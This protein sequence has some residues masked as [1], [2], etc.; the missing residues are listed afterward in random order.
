VIDSLRRLFFTCLAPLLL[1]ACISL[2]ATF[3]KVLS[4]LPPGWFYGAAAGVGI[5]VLYR[6]ALGLPQGFYVLGHELTHMLAAKATGKKILNADI[7]GNWRSGYVVTSGANMWIRLA[8]YAISF[9]NVFL[10]IVWLVASRFYP[11]PSFSY[12]LLAFA[13][14]AMNAEFT[15]RGFLQEQPDLAFSG[16]V[17]S[18]AYALLWAMLFLPVFFWP[19]SEIGWREMVRFYGEWFG[20]SYRWFLWITSSFA[21]V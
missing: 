4:I 16:R 3:G 21:W 11:L 20:K 18:A 12:L 9:H 10:C 5:Y 17:F 1:V 19:A 13:L 14:L 6:L 2:G 8:P 7:A 15:V